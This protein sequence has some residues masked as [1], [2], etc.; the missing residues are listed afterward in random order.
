MIELGARVRFH[1][2]LVRSASYRAAGTGDRRNVHRALAEAT[3]PES[4]PDRRAWHLAHAAVDLDEDMARE[5]EHSAGR[6]QRRGGVAAAAAFLRRATELTPD[7]ALRGLRALA[8]AQA[9]FEAGAS[10]AAQELLTSA[11]LAPLD[12]PSRARLAWLR[13][14]SRPAEGRSGR[15]MFSRRKRRKSPVSQARV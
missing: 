11:E 10:D 7:P 12:E 2:P 1:H 8:A 6:A 4:D 13:P 9:T 15:G 3:D 14:A 5:L